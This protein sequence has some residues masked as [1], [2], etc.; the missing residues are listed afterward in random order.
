M[1]ALN[2]NQ[3]LYRSRPWEL[4][5]NISFDIF[6]IETPMIKIETVKSSEIVRIS[7]LMLEGYRF[8]LSDTSRYSYMFFNYKSIKEVYFKSSKLLHLNLNWNQLINFIQYISILIISNTNNILLKNI[9]RKFS[10]N[11]FNCKNIV[12]LNFFNI[13]LSDS[14]DLL[15]LK[16]LFDFSSKA[17]GYSNIAFSQNVPLNLINN[18]NQ[19]CLHKNLKNKTFNLDLNVI[20]TI[21]FQMKNVNNISQLNFLVNM[22]NLIN[23]YLYVFLFF[24]LTFK[25][26]LNSN[27]KLN[28]DNLNKITNYTYIYN[29]FNNKNLL[30]KKDINFF[31]NF[32][33]FSKLNLNKLLNNRDSKFFFNTNTDYNLNFFGF[34]KKFKDINKNFII[35][36]FSCLYDISSFINW[37]KINGNYMSRFK[38]FYINFVISFDLLN[39]L[40]IPVNSIVTLDNIIYFNSYGKLTSSFGA[41]KLKKRVK[42]PKYIFDF[43]WKQL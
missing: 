8:L 27:L 10:L 19:V 26:I 43:L 32:N 34:K 21:N 13:F 24:D 12:Y 38:T 3:N 22:N 30:K 39:G 23:N 6:S 36:D 16:K 42:D 7:P 15:S 11:T 25:L 28:N 41:L 1:G 40:T 9:Y 31:G 17:F 20:K 5:R 4:N 33:N 14:I 2:H 35:K 37:N 29:F 18:L